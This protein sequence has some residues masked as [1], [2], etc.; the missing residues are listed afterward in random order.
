MKFNSLNVIKCFTKKFKANERFSFCFK[1]MRISIKYA[2][3]LYKS[4][5]TMKERIKEYMDYIG[6]PAGKLAELLEVQRS[7]ISHILNGRNKPGAHF[8]E[9]FLLCFPEVDA[10]WL[11]TGQGTMLIENNE[12]PKEKSV[13]K[14]P[15]K[16]VI[17]PAKENKEEDSP[18]HEKEPVENRVEKVILL[19]TDG[20]FSSYNPSLKNN[21]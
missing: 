17:L 8:I 7:N 19:H 9:R 12:N 6:I 13:I 5:V 20:T 15:E 11:I 18:V 14:K 10:R 16:Q 3:H 21:K 4:V 1:K 2:L